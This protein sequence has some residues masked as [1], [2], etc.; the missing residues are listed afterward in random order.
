MRPSALR[1]AK[2]SAAMVLSRSV[3]GLSGASSRPPASHAIRISDASDPPTLS[4]GATGPVVSEI[5]AAWSRKFGS[6]VLLP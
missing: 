1:R 2:A 6:R 4:E 3:A 5:A